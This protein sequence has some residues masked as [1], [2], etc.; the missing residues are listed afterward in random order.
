VT[1]PDCNYNY[2]GHTE[3]FWAIQCQLIE[4]K[5]IPVNDVATDGVPTDRS[6]PVVLMPNRPN[7]F[8]PATWIHYAI[9][10]PG[11]VELVIYDAGG[12]LVRQLSHTHDS[13]G[14]YRLRWNGKNDE[15]STLP[16][17]VYFYALH[18]RDQTLTNKMLLLR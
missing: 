15:G 10:E 13:P 5:T 2:T 17:G 4:Y 9:Q 1:C 14:S 18:S 8:T 16:G 6:R 3:P 7:P 12:R 11:A